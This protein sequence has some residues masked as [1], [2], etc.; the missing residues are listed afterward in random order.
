MASLF[1]P[2]V[3]R[4][5]PA[6]A[7]PVTHKGKPHVR[8]KDQRGRDVLYPLTADGQRYRAK[9][10]K[11]YGKVKDANGKWVPVKLDTADKQA[12]Q[13]KLNKLAA[14][15]ER[16][17]L[18][19]F[20]P[21]EEHVRRPLADH[22]ADYVAALTAKGDTADHVTLTRQR[23][24]A[25]LAGCGFVFLADADAAKVSEW[26]NALRRGSTPAVV[27]DGEAFTPGQVAE[28]LGVSGTAVANLIRRLNLPASGNGKAR[29]YPRPTVEVLV[30]NR[31][32][33]A[34][35]G[36]VNHYVRA[37]RGFFRWLVKAKRVGSNPMDALAFDRGTAVDVRRARRELTAR[38][39]RRLFDAA[40][41]SNRVFRGLDGQARYT[42]YLAAAG[43]GF[44]A[45]ALT[46]LTPAEFD[47]AAGTVTLPA[48]FNKSRRV[49]VQ[50]IPADVA[51]ELRA[52]LNGKPVGEPV[53]GGT[54][55]KGK[56]AAEMLRGDLQA[57]GIP[58]V[59]KGPDGPEY[60]DFHALRHSYLTMLGKT[61]D[62]RTVQELAGHSRPEITARYVHKRHDDLAD[63]VGKLP[64][65]VPTTAP[66]VAHAV[67]QAVCNGLP[68][69][70]LPCTAEGV[71]G[72]EEQSSEVPEPVGYFADLRR[73]ASTCTS[74]G[75]GTRTR[76][77]RIDSPVL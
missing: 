52:Y 19:L 50:P 29:R 37:V 54:W 4:P 64:S 55:A 60:A 77:L 9:A 38:E 31:A 23:L 6:D 36:T 16:K 44:R 59:V 65:L 24:T 71:N 2:T 51:A 5:V 63:A 32:K 45:N 69:D 15:A 70:A 73:V 25:V 58:Y 1:K 7:V 75:D 43:I 42:L 3:T 40:R 47:F 18:G 53:W 41:T 10:S 76:N 56:K 33:G 57:A 28:L 67:A 66:S 26:L 20:D 49:K 74:E 39:L 34:G 14:V 11:W 72:R 21:Q 8:V 22:L 48:R 17:R 30:A 62:L 68:P 27:P 12:A 61:A 13:A 46:N 35:P